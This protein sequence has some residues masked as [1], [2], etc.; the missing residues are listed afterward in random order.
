MSERG[1]PGEVVYVLL[2]LQAAAGL[3]ASLGELLLMGTPIYAI[4]PVARAVVLVV[5]AAKIVRGRL[6]ALITVVVLEWLGLLGGWLGLL[7]GLL[8]GL[9]PSVTLMALVTE[10][11]LPAAVIMLC[12]R[13][14]AAHPRRRTPPMAT[15]APV[16]TA[17]FAPQTVPFAGVPRF[18]AAPTAPYQGAWRFEGAGTGVAR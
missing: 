14:L 1:G 2:L 15:A 3:L 5:L 11:A 7:L 17:P 8:P 16:A 12:A 9:A 18:S 10:L 13:T 4:L 6:W